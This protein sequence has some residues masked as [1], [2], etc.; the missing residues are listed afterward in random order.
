M[1]DWDRSASPPPPPA[2]QVYL[3]LGFGII[4]VF[5]MHLVVA[6]SLVGV[7]A[8]T[9]G[10]PVAIGG[11]FWILGIGLTQLVYV[12]PA[13]VVAWIIRR[14]LAMGMLIG[15]G[16]TLVLNTACYGS[17]FAAAALN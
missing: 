3:Q 15:A 5:S 1:A 10:E 2:T 13:V 8:A 6:L 14:P 7:A 11:M 17:M 16:L 9:G 4:A 12:G